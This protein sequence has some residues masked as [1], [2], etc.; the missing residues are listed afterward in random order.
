[1]RLD[2]DKQ[3]EL[4][5]KRIEFAKNSL[6]QLGLKIISANDKTIKF[7]YKDELITLYP[8][9]GWFTG[10]TVKDGRGIHNLLK[11]LK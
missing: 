5:P 4:E 6:K 9:S 3:N 1:M 7:V 10:K 11:Q 2:I 8:Y